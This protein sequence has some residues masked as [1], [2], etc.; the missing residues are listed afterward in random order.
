LETPLYQRPS[1]R[2]TLP[3]PAAPVQP[4][5]TP[6]STVLRLAPGRSGEAAAALYSGRALSRPATS[7]SARL[8]RAPRGWPPSPNCA[9]CP[10]P[11]PVPRVSR[12]W[13]T[14]EL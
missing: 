10:S 11:K 14:G 3:H 2:A 9:G 7:T 5:P 1:L 13:H 12:R 8:S 4:Q 6:R